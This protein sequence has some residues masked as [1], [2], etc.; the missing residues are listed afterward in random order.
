MRVALH[1]PFWRRRLLVPAL[2]LLGT[3]LVVAAA[4]TLPRGLKQRGIAQRAEALRKEVAQARLVVAELEGRA[5]RAR[6][7]EAAEK[8]FFAEVVGTRRTALVPTLTELEK[9]VAQ[10]G[11]KAGGRSFGA[12]PVKEMPLLRL[13]MSVSLTG[14][15]RQ[16]VEFLHGLERSKHFVT[17]D[18]VE[19]RERRSEDEA[20]E[21]ALNVGVS[22][23]FRAE[24]ASEPR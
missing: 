15:Y 6:E 17:V 13:S 24:E 21:G 20:A 18:K 23:W 12:D 8:R 14:G 11:L 19:M 2:A 16:L 7:N 4:Y 5:E 3:N 1:R 9:L 22:A 10:P